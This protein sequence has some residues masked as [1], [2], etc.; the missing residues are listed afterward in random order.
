MFSEKLNVHAVAPC[1]LWLRACCGS[2][3]AVAVMSFHLIVCRITILCVY[4]YNGSCLFQAWFV[5]MPSV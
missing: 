4:V 1:M 5:C 2:V 3:H